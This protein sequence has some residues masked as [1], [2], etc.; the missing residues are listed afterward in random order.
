MKNNSNKGKQVNTLLLEQRTAEVGR[1]ESRK[2]EQRGSGHSSASPEA[3]PGTGHGGERRAAGPGVAAP[4]PCGARRGAGTAIRGAHGGH[5]EGTGREP[6]PPPSRGLNGRL[7]AANRPPPLEPPATR[8]LL[9]SRAAFHAAPAASTNQRWRHGRPAQEP[10]GVV[11]R[12]GDGGNPRRDGCRARRS[13][14]PRWFCRPLSSYLCFLDHR[15]A[16]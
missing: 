13:R 9:Q 15:G 10:L 11:V 3:K 5:A 1:H 7:T 6:P 12:R 8:R 4:L 14:R 16:F 2:A